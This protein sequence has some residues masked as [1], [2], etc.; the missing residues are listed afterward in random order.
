[1]RWVLDAEKSKD[2]RIAVVMG[3]IE[4]G[5]F[6]SAASLFFAA[7]LDSAWDPN[8]HAPKDVIQATRKVDDDDGTTIRDREGN[9]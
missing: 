6:G 2:N 4:C 3:M 5:F 8:A 1:M 7:K 9:H